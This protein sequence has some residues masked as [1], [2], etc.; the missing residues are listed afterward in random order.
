M[1]N[2]LSKK[3]LC[4][5]PVKNI[6]KMREMVKNVRFGANV[7]TNPL[8]INPAVPNIKVYKKA[9]YTS[10]CEVLTVRQ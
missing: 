7:D 4:F 10:N 1:Y 9:F 5:P 6:T 8:I 2:T 3:N